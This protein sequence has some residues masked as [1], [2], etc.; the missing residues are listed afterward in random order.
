MGSFGAR[1]PS[2]DVQRAGRGMSD[3][4]HLVRRDIRTVRRML[5][6]V[7]VL[8]IATAAKLFIFA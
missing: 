3:E 4:L 2:E 1:S 8:Q 5:L 7:L 6:L